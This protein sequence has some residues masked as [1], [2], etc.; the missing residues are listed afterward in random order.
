MIG[1]AELL[2]TPLDLL[3]PG[4]FVPARPQRELR[5]LV[6][7]RTALVRQRAQVTN[8]VQKTLEGAN[9]KLVSVAPP[10]NWAEAS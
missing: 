7:Y 1:E 8:R 5:E 4:S 6:R 10:R 3:G 2:S 9:I